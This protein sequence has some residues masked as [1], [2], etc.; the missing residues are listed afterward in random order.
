MKVSN[1]HGDTIE[2]TIKFTVPK[3]PEGITIRL[4]NSSKH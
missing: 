4:E 1:F 3:T 2:K